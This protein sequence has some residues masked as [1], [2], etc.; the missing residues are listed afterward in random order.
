MP[1]LQQCSSS[2]ILSILIWQQRSRSAAAS[3]GALNYVLPL[4]LTETVFFYCHHMTLV[5][6][7]IHYI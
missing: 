2:K 1:C 4:W 3:R 7:K 6:F 5:Y